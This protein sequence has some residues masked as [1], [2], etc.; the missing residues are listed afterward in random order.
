[1][2]SAQC[3]KFWTLTYQQLVFGNH[4][5]SLAIDDIY[6]DWQVTPRRVQISRV[7]LQPKKKPVFYKLNEYMKLC[8]SLLIKTTRLQ[9]VL[10]RQMNLLQTTLVRNLARVRLYSLSFSGRNNLLLSIMPC[11]ARVNGISVAVLVIH[12]AINYLCTC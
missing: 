5:I 1:M 2:W 7:P 10:N 3:A 4:N 6:R 12:L 8:H 9:P 11:T